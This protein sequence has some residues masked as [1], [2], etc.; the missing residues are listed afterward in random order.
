MNYFR[1]VRTALDALVDGICRHRHVER[2]T[3]MQM[4]AAHLQTMREE[5]FS[6]ETPNIA[7]ED[8]LCR[9]AYLYCHTAVNANLCE[10]CIRNSPDVQEHIHHVL[11]TNGELRVCAFGG[12]PGTEL[13]AL[14]KYLCNTR[15]GRPQGDI[16]FTLLDIVG[17]WCESWNALETAIKDRLR[18]RFGPRNCWPF[19]ISKTFLSFDMTQIEQYAN[20]HH[21]FTHDL[22]VMNYVLSEI[23]GEN[24]AF[25]GLINRMSESAPRGAKFL[26]VDRSQDVIIDRAREHLQNAGLTVGEVHR[27]NSNM[28]GDEQSDTLLEYYRLIRRNPRVQWQGAFWVVG[29]KP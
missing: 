20:L 13:L 21:V 3:A 22:Y 1:L 4:A 23:F 25:G 6:G 29:T 2:T 14:A 10:F 5:W 17:E 27:T 7:Y 28:D 19:T 11:D 9:F 15:E 16:S 12:G 18:T 26:I 24:E 8:P